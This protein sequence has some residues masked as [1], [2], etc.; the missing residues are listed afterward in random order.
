MPPR[1]SE[2]TVQGKAHS[3][4]NSLKEIVCKANK[5]LPQAGL[6]AGT[7]G[8]VSQRDPETG[9]IAIKPSGVSFNDLR[10]EDIVIV[11]VNGKK[12]EGDHKPS[13]DTASHCFVYRSLA[14]VGGI[15]HTHSKYATVFAIRG[16]EI[17]V[18]TTLA[19]DVFGQ[20]IPVSGYATIG[21]EAIGQEIVNNLDGGSAVLLRNHGVFTVGS[22]AA[23]A[24]RSATYVEETAEVSYLAKV[25]G[26]VTPL[27]T[28]AV[29][30]AREWYIEKYGQKP[31][32]HGA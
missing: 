26:E 23:Q 28:E 12:I 18:L 5:E 2:T 11:D 24:V 19:A 10:P 22:T 1:P 17:P 15:V 30:Q 16:E 20:P 25:L 27:D 7:S 31:V 8:N 4:L 6:V 29:R 13:V 14:D 3:M 21:G 9:L 32:K